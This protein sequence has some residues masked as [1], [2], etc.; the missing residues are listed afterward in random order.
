[1]INVTMSRCK[2]CSKTPSFGWKH[3]G[4]REYCYAHKEEGMVNLKHPPAPK[5]MTINGQR[6][7]EKAVS[8]RIRVEFPE[9]QNIMFNKTIIGGRTKRRPDILIKTKHSAIIVEVDENQHITYSKDEEIIRVA[10]IMEDISVPLVLI[11]FN[12]DSYKIGNKRI[13]SCWD[14]RGKLKDVDNWDQRCALLV[15]TIREW[16]DKKIENLVIIKLFFDE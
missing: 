11:R 7:K 3:C 16:I 4:S 8:E 5:N 13:R 2:C 14:R 10:E 12:P 9:I 1:M 6:T 15:N